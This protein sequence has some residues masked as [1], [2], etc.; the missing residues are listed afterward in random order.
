MFSRTIRKLKKKLQISNEQVDALGDRLMEHQTRIELMQV[1][2]VTK[3]EE[4][5]LFIAELHEHMGRSVSGR[6]HTLQYVAN[7]RAQA[8]TMQSIKAILA[9][10]YDADAALLRRLACSMGTSHMDVDSVVQRAGVLSQ[11]NVRNAEMER[12]VRQKQ[13]TIDELEIELEDENGY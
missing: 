3:D 10:Q 9:G 11:V 12:T 7:L 5:L 13:D 2:I 8:E 6:E 1:E 4:Y